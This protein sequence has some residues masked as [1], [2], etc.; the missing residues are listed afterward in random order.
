MPQSYMEPSECSC[1]DHPMLHS[2]SYGHSWWHFRCLIIGLGCSVAY[3]LTCLVAG[4]LYYITIKPKKYTF[5]PGVIEQPSRGCLK[6]PK[7]F[8][9]FGGLSF[10]DSAAKVFEGPGV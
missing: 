4:L 8:R 5:F 1:V 2:R 6:A 7:T 10:G 3:F 9:G